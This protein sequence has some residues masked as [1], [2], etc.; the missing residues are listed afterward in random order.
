MT[1]QDL[2]SQAYFN[3][4]HESGKALVKSHEKAFN[5]SEVIL[6]IYHR[7]A[8]KTLTPSQVFQ[9][10]QEFTRL[11]STPLTSIRRAMTVLMKSGELIKTEHMNMGLYG[12]REHYY[13][14]K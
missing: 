12:K 10:Y 13:R 8:T 3:T 1:T 2:F 6:G 14:L 4:T 9:K 11:T 7:S 5:Q